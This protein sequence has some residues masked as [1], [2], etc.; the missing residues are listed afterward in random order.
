MA[1][2]EARRFLLDS[3]AYGL[4][5]DWED[6]A[7]EK[8]SA[9]QGAPAL[10]EFWENPPV[11][12]GASSDVDLT[13]EDESNDP[14]TLYAELEK[15]TGVKFQVDVDRDDD[16]E[17]FG[18]MVSHGADTASVTIRDQEELDYVLAKVKEIA[19]LDS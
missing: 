18:V 2:S 10:A 3:M 12:V 4:W 17:I 16:G 6:E 7:R 5:A 8:Q 14:E 11:E 1:I 9:A 19:G 15:E 13:M